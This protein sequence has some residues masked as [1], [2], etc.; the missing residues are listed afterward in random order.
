MKQTRKRNKTVFIGVRVPQ[1]AGNH[2]REVAKGL[3]VSKSEV[4]RKLIMAWIGLT[5]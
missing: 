2:I 1:E 3:N 5:R 4:V